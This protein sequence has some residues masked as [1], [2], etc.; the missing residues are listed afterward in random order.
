MS[1]ADLNGQNISVNNVVT[2][3]VNFGDSALD[4]YVQTGLSS[5]FSGPFTNPIPA[6]GL[7]RIFGKTAYISINGISGTSISGIFMTF[8]TTIFPAP[9][10]NVYFPIYVIDNGVT[11]QGTCV[12]GSN[13]IMAIY[14]GFNSAFT[15][16][17]TIGFQN[18]TVYYTYA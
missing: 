5:E 6:T 7:Y 17:S 3:S 10:Q 13:G 11:V 1:I 4:I 18:F 12:I 14:N 15:P 9:V 16:S 2:N 8:G